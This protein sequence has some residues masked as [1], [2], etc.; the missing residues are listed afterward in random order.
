LNAPFPSAAASD[1]R[2]SRREDARLV[3]GRGLFV[4]DV[5]RHGMLHAVF[6]R[7]PHAR[8]LLGAIDIEAARAVPGVKALLLAADLGGA[9]QPPINP[10]LPATGA[11]AFPLLATGQVNYVG[12]PVAMVVAAS[13]AAAEAAAELVDIDYAPQDAQADLQ[14]GAATVLSTAYRRSS[15]V[16]DTG[17]TQVSLRHVQPRVCAAPME[18]RAAVA[19]FAGA[20]LTAWL[21]TQAP[22]RAR[23]DI[24]ALL[25]LGRDAVRVIAPDVGGAFGA[26][27]SVYPEDL[28]V[29][30]AAHRL[31]AAVKWTSRRGEDFLAATH[32]RGATLSGVLSVD[33]HWRFTHLEARLDF[34]LGAWLPFSAAMPLRNAARILP[35]PYLVHD[36]DIEARGSL[37]NAAAMNIYRGAGRPEA[38][39]LMERLIDKAARTLGVDPVALRK[40]N[41]ITP[42]HMPHDTPTGER[43][44]SGNYGEALERACA[45]FGYD[46]ERRA[47][48]AREAAGELV[49]IGVAMYIEPCGQGWESA[50]VIL[51][52]DG[53]ATAASGSAAQGQGHETTYATIAA[54]ALG[55]DPGSIHVVHGDTRECPDG[56]G[57]LA[58]RSIAI[59]GSA[60]REAA[61]AAKAR[62]EAGEALPLTCDT[63]Y[64]APGEAWSYGCVMVRLSIDRDTGVPAIERLVWVDDAG[65]ILSPHLA[66]GQLHGGLAQGIGQALCEAIV[67]DDTGQLLTGSFLDYC[68]PRAGD[69][70]PIELE[71]MHV[72]ATANALGAKG[73][74]EA[75]TIGAP[76]AILNA[77]LD[78]LAP[79]GVTDLDFPLTA[80]RLWRTIHHH[81]SKGDKP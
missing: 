79:L 40:R 75:G 16:A 2:P 30:F 18:T 26:K 65:R 73:V 34:P 59:G 78:A 44:D 56:I 62:R 41:L 53:T 74:G 9:C 14:A 4:H 45:R 39:L 66:E 11:P 5:S 81:T 50:R 24:A 25:G 31:G 67:Y 60:V 57:A 7:S 76:A 63:I 1:A 54:E 68:L 29:A 49:G 22:S 43:L 58:S 37:S 70:P 69:L 19:E 64:R 10:L 61:L 27:A 32:G 38:A 13:H 48:R 71:S 77:A 46:T 51:H 20:H 80:A 42:E 47:Q 72:P 36:I 33:R 17:T 28:L 52:A 15:G 23:D 21:P 35:G 55:C 12:Q 8:A 6:V 3:T